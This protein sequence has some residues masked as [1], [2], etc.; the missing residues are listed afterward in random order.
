MVIV[1]CDVS[2]NHGGFCWFD[3]KGDVSGYRFFHDVMKF[4]KADPDHGI[5]TGMKKGKE[6][7]GLAYDL[8]RASNYR[9]LF[10]THVIGSNVDAD[11]VLGGDG[12]FQLRDSYFSIEGYAINQGKSSTNRLLQIAEL[13]GMLKDEVYQCGGKMRIHDPMTVKL[14]AC[15][16]KATKMEMRA[17][18]AN[19]DGFLLPD[20][21]FKV[22]KI[23]GKGE[24]LDGPGTDVIDAYWLG[25]MLVTEMM[26]RSGI[27]LM[28]DLP[29]NQI[30]VFNRVTKTYPVNIL[31]RPFLGATDD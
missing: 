10:Q 6:E 25:K 18:A 24:D 8:R 1:G 30:K 3:S 15:H 2:L 21:L 13:T 31:A 17:A 27:L 26:L 4:V 12:P 22:K 29:E 11:A 14:F 9:Q 19:V 23:K 5:H 16:G 20:E 7:T 28:S